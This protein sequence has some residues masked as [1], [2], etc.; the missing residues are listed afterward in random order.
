MGS[1][2]TGWFNAGSNPT[3]QT[4]CDVTLSRSGSTVTVNWGVTMKLPSSASYLGTGSLVVACS[5][6]GAS[7]SGTIKAHSS[8]WSGTTEHS[9]SGSFTFTNASDTTFTVNFSSSSDYFSSSGIFSTS[10][11]C[12]CDPGVVAPTIYSF[13]VTSRTVNSITCSF[14]CSRAD[15]WYYRKAQDAGF[16]QGSTTGVTSGSFTLTGLTPNTTYTISFIA[17]NWV[18]QS[19]GTYKDAFRQLD[20][21]TYDIGKISSVS[22]FN[23]GD[24][25]TLIATNPSGASLNL[26][27]KIGNTQVASKSV[28]TGT[29]TIS[30]TDSELDSI[31]RLY[32]SSNSQTATFILTTIGTYTNSKTAT[33]TLTGNQKTAYTGASGKKRAKVY[34]GVGGSVKRAVVWIGNNGRKRCI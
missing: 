1:A 11:S 32:G 12:Q 18:S 9:Y 34:V 20:S 7:S 10:V 2:S 5:C 33:V 26:T 30:F 29:N 25:T 22:N 24:N 15:T 6:G 17:R 31:Y 19:A 4:K 14:T 23:H 3:V 8:T 16:T 27:I 28:T 21:S 13:T